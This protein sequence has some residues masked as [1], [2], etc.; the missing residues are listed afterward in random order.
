M[1]F[2]L[3]V[4]LA[5]TISLRNNNKLLTRA[6]ILTLRSESPEVRNGPHDTPRGEA[7]LRLPDDPHPPVQA[8]IMSFCVALMDVIVSSAATRTFLSG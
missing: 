7:P 2:V 5:I 1:L 8:H 6:P 4:I 3:S